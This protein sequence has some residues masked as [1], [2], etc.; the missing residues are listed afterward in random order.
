MPRYLK[1]LYRLLLVL[2][3]T[4]A[5]GISAFAQEK[6]KLPKA[7]KPKIH[8]PVPGEAPPGFFDNDGVTSERSMMVDPNV[9]IRV[10]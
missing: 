5:F 3:L 8:A 6:E 1:D 4:G 10:G 2:C 9:A 7:P